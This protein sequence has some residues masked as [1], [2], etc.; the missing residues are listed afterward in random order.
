MH[1]YGDEEDEERH[2]MDGLLATMLA[3][4]C[5]SLLLYSTKIR[6]MLVSDRLYL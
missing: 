5:E 6:S 1:K 2:K 3:R 4:V